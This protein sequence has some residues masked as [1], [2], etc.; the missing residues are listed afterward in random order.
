MAESDDICFK[1]AELEAGLFQ[2]LL[3]I[4]TVAQSRKEIADGQ[5]P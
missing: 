3:T 1:V 2:P 5:A 4:Y